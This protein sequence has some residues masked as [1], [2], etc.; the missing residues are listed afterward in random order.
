MIISYSI[1]WRQKYNNWEPIE[2]PITD[3]A[4]A[5]AVINSIRSKL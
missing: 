5:L 2:F 1:K 4:E 3:F